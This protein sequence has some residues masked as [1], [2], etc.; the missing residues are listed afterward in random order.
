MALIPNRTGILLIAFYFQLCLLLANAEPRE[1]LHIVYVTNRDRAPLPHYEERISRIMLDVQDFF[2]SEMERNGFGSKTFRLDLDKNGQ[3]KVHLV[4]LDWDFDKTHKFTPRELRPVIA[5][6]LKKEGMDIEQEY[7]ITF[8]NAYWKEGDTWKY[9]VVYTGMGNPVKGATWVVDHKLLDPKN[10]IPGLTDTINDRGQKLTIGQFN[11]KMIGGVAHEFGHSLGLPHNR[12]TS[13][14]F[15]KYGKALMGAGNYT[16]RQE[17]LGKRPHGTH[18]T[19][20]HAFIISLHPLFSGHVPNNFYVP[21]I[22]LDELSFEIKKNKLQISGKVVPA[23]EVAGVVLYH[24]PLPTGINRDYDAF[25]YLAAMDRTGAFSVSMPALE[26][27]AC[28]LHIKVYFKNG[29]HTQFSFL[30]EK[31]KNNGL[32]S[33]RKDYLI[34]QVKHAFR[35]RDAKKL[36]NLMKPLKIYDPEAAKRAQLFLKSAEQWEN[37][38]IPAEVPNKIRKISLSSWFRPLWSSE[39]RCPQGLFAHAPSHYTYT[40]GRKWRKLKTRIGIQRGRTKGSTVFVIKGDGKALY[41]SP[42]IRLTDGE[43]EAE[44]DVTGISKLELIT[45]PGP[46]GNEQDWSIWIEPVLY[47]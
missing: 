33:L 19:K 42:L 31:G 25:S 10:M 29:M 37:F 46:D 7:I 16:Y 3:A 40:L 12:E 22:F 44:V 21:N 15:R 9:D 47:R 17:R 38:H 6:E 27:T 39:R 13:S 8:E 30:Q 11:V 20:A 4:K 26:D 45:K 1:F 43:V 23:D 36:R 28:A 32:K 34:K 35:M 5:R 41:R 18:I 24:D 2:R 14:E